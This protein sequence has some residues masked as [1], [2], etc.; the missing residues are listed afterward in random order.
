MSEVICSSCFEIEDTTARFI[1]LPYLCSA[2]E[3]YSAFVP[4]TYN[5]GVPCRSAIDSV[6][7][8][9]YLDDPCDAHNRDV[10]DQFDADAEL[11][12]DLTAQLDEAQAANASLTEE[13][14]FCDRRVRAYQMISTECDKRAA[15]LEKEVARLNELLDLQSQENVD[16]HREY[17]KYWHGVVGSYQNELRLTLELLSAERNK[18]WLQKLFS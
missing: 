11:I 13:L 2:C 17:R 3:K 18:T 14:D 15:E 16:K 5:S 7:E 12:A 10:F 4:D 9:Q 8:E 1:E 6:Q